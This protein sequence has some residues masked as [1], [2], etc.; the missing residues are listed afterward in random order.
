[1]LQQL[2]QFDKSILDSNIFTKLR[3]EEL[4]QINKGTD[5]ARFQESDPEL[6]I[7]IRHMSI[8]EKKIIQQPRHGVINL[9]S[10]LL[11]DFRGV[12]ATFWAMYN[13]QSTIGT[14]LHKIE[15][16]SIDTGSVISTSSIG[17]NYNKSYLWNTLNLY[18]TGCTAIQRALHSVSSGH[19]LKSV[20]QG[21]EKG[22][23][24][25]YP[26]QNTLS[27]FKYDL[28]NKEDSLT[29]FLPRARV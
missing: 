29:D 25:S 5:L 10:G 7:S 16:R 26:D 23:Y 8:L 1:M 19:D 4:N 13:Q 17:L 3:A 24:F 14:T 28:F 27:E 12:M 6:V 15:D 20:N 22:A 21:R 11:P 2:A 9:H 18:K